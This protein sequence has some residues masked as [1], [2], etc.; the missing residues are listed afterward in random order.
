VDW[1]KGTV[2][3]K[4]QLAGG[5][6]G[7]GSTLCLFGGIVEFPKDATPLVDLAAE[8]DAS[9][10]MIHREVQLKVLPQELPFVKIIACLDDALEI[11][12]LRRSVIGPDVVKAEQGLRNSSTPAADSG[13]EALANRQ[14]DRRV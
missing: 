13:E 4:P 5:R 12:I 6:L 2:T 14:V 8:D 7:R 10:V 1:A 9:R 11:E 3:T